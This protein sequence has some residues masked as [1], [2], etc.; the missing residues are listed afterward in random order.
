MKIINLSDLAP[1]WCW[2][3]DEF[4]HL[5]HTWQ[6]YTSQSS[7]IPKFIPKHESIAR[8]MTAWKAV[9]QAK[10]S[11]ILVSHG[12]RPTFF[13][14]SF[15]KK[16]NPDLPHLGYSLNF[17]DLPAGKQHKLMANAFQQ[18][19]RFV[20]YSTVE[21]KLYSDYFDIPIERIDMLHWAIHAP[22]IDLSQPPIEPGAYICAIGSQARDYQT[23]FAAM[24]QLKHIKLV[25]VAT[26]ENIQHLQVPE[27]VTIHTQIPLAQA[28]NILAHSRFTIVP[29]RDNQVP[30]GNV[31]IVSSMFFKKAMIV[32][33]SQ[34]VY[35]YV[36]N[37]SNGLFYEPQ[38][39]GDLVN[40]ISLLW[41]D[42]QKTNAL[43]ENGFAFA[44]EHCTE[45]TVVNYF[46]NYLQQYT[47]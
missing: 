38:E 43:A 26:L 5:P 36:K 17:T 6:S 18:P 44:N 11:A 14:A 31:T 32:T 39:V 35:D 9:K 19:N 37:E 7:V 4:T 27:N 8:A 25:V 46:T 28:H 10:K 2:L 42:T 16:L 33:N 34:G 41:E 22:K 40:K 29:L 13:G 20:T 30:C 3:K 23:L 12:P 21:R 47:D 15:A 1:D 24:K 45:K